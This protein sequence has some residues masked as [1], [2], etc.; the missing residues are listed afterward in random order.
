[1]TVVA[2]TR[3]SRQLRADDTRAR[4]FKAAAQLLLQHGYHGITVEKIAV[5]A[6]VA[7]GTF[8]LHFPTKDAVVLELVR[9]QCGAARQARAE[10]M[11]RG[12]GPIARLQASVLTLGERAGLSRNV[13]GAVLSASLQDPRVGDAVN[14]IFEE[15]L[16]EMRQDAAAAAHEG[17]FSRH[18]DPDTVAMQLMAAY[19]GS[20]LHF[21]TTPRAQSLLEVLRPLVDN[22]L[23]GAARANVEHDHAK[24]SA[25]DSGS[26]PVHDDRPAGGRRLRRRV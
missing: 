11:A 5:A 3:T 6:G 21:T 7:K 12:D 2:R 23:A 25:R 8:F 15:V 20:V 14:A 17:L 22:A 1:M 26:K 10:A 13:S 18:V 19:L 4:L 9:L 24:Q 16:V